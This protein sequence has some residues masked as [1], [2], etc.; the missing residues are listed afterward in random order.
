MDVTIDERK[1]ISSG[2]Y[3]LL[4]KIIIFSFRNNNLCLASNFFKMKTAELFKCHEY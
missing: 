2:M 1:K 3:L 4:C